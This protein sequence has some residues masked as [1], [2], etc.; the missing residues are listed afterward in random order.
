MKNAVIVTNAAMG[1]LNQATSGYPS[2]STF[3]F[4]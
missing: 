4:P 3:K 2:T 1:K